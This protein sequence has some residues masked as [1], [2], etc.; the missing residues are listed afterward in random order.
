MGELIGNTIGS[1]VDLGLLGC[2]PGIPL[3]KF[4]GG[5]S[6]GGGYGLQGLQGLLTDLIPLLN[7]EIGNVTLG[8][9][10]KYTPST[11]NWDE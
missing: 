2:V 11:R 7:L 3:S 5:R 6:A 9:L 1:E 8:R 4:K 10:T